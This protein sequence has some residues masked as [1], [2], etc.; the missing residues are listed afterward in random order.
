[1]V[2]F[3]LNQISKQLADS[4]CTGGCDWPMYAAAFKALL[5]D[6][7]KAYR[8]TSECKI[9]NWSRE[10]IYRFL[11][12]NEQ[13]NL[14][15]HYKQLVAKLYFDANELS[16]VK[17]N[18]GPIVYHCNYC[19]S[20]ASLRQFSAPDTRASRLAY[21]CDGGCDAHVGFHKGDRMPLGTL[22]DAPLRRYRQSNLQL[23]KSYEE[24]NKISRKAA[25]EL[26]AAEMKMALHQVK[27]A[28]LDYRQSVELEKVLLKLAR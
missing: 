6:L 7:K 18:L 1:M 24:T 27:I 10:G 21:I 11:N 23:L 19:S 4:G 12:Q 28:R 5:A 14:M 3:Y 2:R 20:T 17:T 22:A 8:S 15:H 13:T 25:Y 16:P 26:V 9:E